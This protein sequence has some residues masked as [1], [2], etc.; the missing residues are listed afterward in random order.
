MRRQYTGFAISTLLSKI[1][2]LDIAAIMQEKGNAV[3]QLSKEKQK[4]GEQLQQAHADLAR[5]AALIKDLQSQAK[6]KDNKHAGVPAEQVCPDLQL[7]QAS[8]SSTANTAW[9]S[10]HILSQ[11]CVQKSRRQDVHEC[12]VHMLC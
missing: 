4:K 12:P 9:H 5:Q 3:E 7:Q 6:K 1:F 10:L 8:C 2:C 11:T